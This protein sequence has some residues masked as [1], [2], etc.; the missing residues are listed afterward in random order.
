M[1]GI[2]SDSAIHNHCDPA[3]AKREKDQT[4]I[5]CFIPI[6]FLSLVFAHDPDAELPDWKQYLRFGIVNAGSNSTGLASYA[7][8]KRTSPRSFRDLRFY[9][10]Y[11]KDDTDIRLRLKTSRMFLSF[12]W[13][14]SFNTLIYEKNTF[15]D[16]NLRYHY[17]QGL[18]WLIRNSADGNMMT[19]ELGIAFDN[20]DYLN[21]EQ[22]TSYAKSGF[23]A[24]RDFG[25][26]H[27]KIEM[28][29]FHQVSKQVD[30]T[31]LSRIQLVSE[32]QLS[33][34]KGTALIF[35]FTQDFPL[36]ES[37]NFET[38][39]VFLTFALKQPLNWT[40]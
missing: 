11:F 30:D 2:D 22:K 31:D 16:V 27:T 9:G 4:V 1:D 13:L 8:L 34:K 7:R 25:P 35:G 21:T 29:Y 17:N 20:S 38:A 10:H 18:G 36:D 23:T 14:Y 5:K 26:L 24:D 33:I 32:A 3:H 37:F 39:S 12:D 6:L 15:I 40:F 28:D 19:F